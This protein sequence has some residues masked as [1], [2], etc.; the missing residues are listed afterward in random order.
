MVKDAIADYSDRELHAALEVNLANY[1]S[2]IV[3]TAVIV[4]SISNL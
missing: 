4:D 3:S 1:A 2:A